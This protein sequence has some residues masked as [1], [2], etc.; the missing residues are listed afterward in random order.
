[1]VPGGG[2]SQG[3]HGYLL[4]MTVRALPGSTNSVGTNAQAHLLVMSLTPFNSHHWGA[5]SQAT[6]KGKSGDSCKNTLETTKYR[7]GH[8]AYPTL[9]YCKKKLAFKINTKIPCRKST[10]YLY[11]IYDQSP[12]LN[13]HCS[14]GIVFEFHM[15]MHDFM[16]KVI[17]TRKNPWLLSE[18]I[19]WN[20]L[21]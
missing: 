15:H 1:M 12:L 3:C 13:N 7:G 17:C 9:Q 14:L 21:I 11:P 5:W 6:F 19:F 8:G 16:K 2:H 20:R 4:C 10:R 18:E